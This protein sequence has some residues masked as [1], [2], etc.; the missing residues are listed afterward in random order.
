MKAAMLY[1][2]SLIVGAVL[3]VTIYKSIEP[4]KAALHHG[5]A[6]PETGLELD[7][8]GK[9]GAVNPAN[10]REQLSKLYKTLVRFRSI[11]G[12][13]PKTLDEMYGANLGFTKSDIKSVD[14]EHADAADTGFVAQSIDGRFL[15]PRLDGSAKPASPK[16]G[17]RDVWA[18]SPIYVRRNVVKHIDRS[19]ALNP[20]G[21]M[22]VLWSDGKIDETP[23]TSMVFMKDPKSTRWIG[24]FS[25]EA[26]MSKETRTW[27][28]MHD[29]VSLT[30][31]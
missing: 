15:R 26:G 8:Q 18:V 31:R 14:A 23:I 28:Q 24:G 3:G 13:L 19:V 6:V 12:G 22:L 1:S 16:R 21:A 10:G 20:Q 30:S 2:T 7:E 27:L 17:E 25:G 4:G 9:T 5:V 11:K 29:Q